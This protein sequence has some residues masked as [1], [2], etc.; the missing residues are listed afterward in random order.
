MR[1]GAIALGLCPS[2]AL[3]TP[4][5]SC[6]LYEFLN[7]QGGLMCGRYFCPLSSIVSQWCLEDTEGSLD[8]SQKG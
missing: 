4:G 1:K 8:C 7:G 3:R 6:N 2:S 5:M